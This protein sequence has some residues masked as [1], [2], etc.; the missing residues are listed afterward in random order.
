MNKSIRKSKLLVVVVCLLAF[1]LSCSLVFARDHG[2]GGPGLFG[3]AVVSGLAIGAVVASISDR[4][5][6]VVVGGAPYYYYDD[7][8]YQSAPGGYVVVAP[9]AAASIKEVPDGYEPV[10]LNGTTYYFNNGAY[11]IYTPY[12]YQSVPP[13]AAAGATAIAVKP[14]SAVVDK[15][16]VFTVNIPNKSGGYKPVVIKRSGKGFVGPQGEYYSEFPEVSQLETMYG[17]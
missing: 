2:G 7:V 16:T 9:P 5:T 1:S 17:R 12:G 10:I 3:A 11:Y 14:S 4:H 13:P 6:T 15:E 8:Y